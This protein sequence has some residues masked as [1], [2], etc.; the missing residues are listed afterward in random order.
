M[1][2][3][4]LAITAIDVARRFHVLQSGDLV[5]ATAVARLHLTSSCR[6]Q[7]SNPVYAS[8]AASTPLLVF[9]FIIKTV[10]P[11]SFINQILVTSNHRY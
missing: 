8:T 1:M 5:H 11:I 4:S 2:H 3:P 6:E 7:L 9:I 10:L